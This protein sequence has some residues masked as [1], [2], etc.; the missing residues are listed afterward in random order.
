MSVKSP[1]GRDG[2]VLLA[3]DFERCGHTNH[4]GGRWKAPQLVPR[5]RIEGP[6]LPVG[7]STREYDIPASH[8]ERR[9]EDGFEVM[10]PDALARI[11]IPCLKLAKMIG[12]ARARANRPEDASYP[13]KKPRA[14]AFGT[15]PFGRKA[16]ILLFAGM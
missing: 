14:S 2:Y 12:G 4:A 7:R 1:T 9:P 11:Q 6:E 10:L 16:Q 13:T 3:I 15:P 8:Q 5:A